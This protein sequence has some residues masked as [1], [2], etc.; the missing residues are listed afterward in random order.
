MNKPK[1]SLKVSVCVTTFNVVSY[2][3]QTIESI[4]LQKTD[5]TYEI[6]IADDLSNDGTRDILEELRARYPEKIVLFY[7]E[8]KSGVCKL[9]YLL[10]MQ[11]KGE[12]IAWLDGDDWWC[13]DLK[14]Q[15]QVDY[16]DSHAHSSG[17]HT[18]WRNLH[19]G[20]YIDSHIELTEREQ[21]MFGKTYVEHILNSGRG[22]GRF[23]SLLCRRAILVSWFERDPEIMLGT[24]HVYANDDAIFCIL[25]HE[26]LLYYMD[27]LTTVYT[28]RNGSLSVT[29]D[30]RRRAWNSYYTFIMRL[31]IVNA[32][33]LSSSTR[34]AVCHKSLN[35]I[36]YYTYNEYMP[37]LARQAFNVNKVE[38]NGYKPTIGIRLLYAG[39]I[40]RILNIL[41]KPLM[42]VN[43]RLCHRAK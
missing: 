17:V 6:I 36:M 39:S 21:S 5:F 22:V 27:D 19:N 43:Y 26:G 29:D 1:I 30:Y 12:Y 13:D 38:G 11:A 37:Q 25:G 28:I 41:L 34:F 10:V 16:L 31:Y 14:L 9:N 33:A 42:F 4:L 24:D 15:K 3:R 18:A 32:F 20:E 2:I 7:P 8:D 35:A 40:S 23:S